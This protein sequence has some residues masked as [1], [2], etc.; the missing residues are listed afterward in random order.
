MKGKQYGK[1]EKTVKDKAAKLMTR[2]AAGAKGKPSPKM[3]PMHRS[4]G[5]GR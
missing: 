4:G 1:V 5:R 3:K 2:G